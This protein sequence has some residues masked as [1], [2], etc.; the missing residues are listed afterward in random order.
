MERYRKI[1]CGLIC[2]LNLTNFNILSI[3]NSV[4][5]Q[6]FRFPVSV[7]YRYAG[8]SYL[9]ITGV[10]VTVTCLLQVCG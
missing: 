7:Y 1:P 2:Q 6:V 3:M 8:F 9:F 5:S 10:R 4:E